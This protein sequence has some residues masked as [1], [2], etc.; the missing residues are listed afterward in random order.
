MSSSERSAVSIDSEVEG[1]NCSEKTATIP[2]RIAHV[3]Y[4][5]HTLIV[6]YSA[7]CR[8]LRIIKL[9]IQWSAL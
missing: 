8:L 5:V 1:P 7:K 3:V 4:S 9:D 6:N 2:E